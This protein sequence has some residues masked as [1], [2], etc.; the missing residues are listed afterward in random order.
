MPAFLLK[1][2]YLKATVKFD[3]PNRNSKHK[4][5]RIVLD[6]T[7]KVIEIKICVPVVSVFLCLRS[8]PPPPPTLTTQDM[9]KNTRV[10]KYREAVLCEYTD[11]IQER[12]TEEHTC[13][14][15]AELD[16]LTGNVLPL[17]VNSI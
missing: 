2:V 12:A 14:R 3:R 7:F 13:K 9:K 8:T 5:S 10:C 4:K 17:S 11:H 16:L 1:H 6:L 15:S